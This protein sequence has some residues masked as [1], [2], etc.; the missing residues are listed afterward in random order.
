MLNSYASHD[1]I[2]LY[3]LSNGR[4][5]VLYAHHFADPSK[6]YTLKGRTYVHTG[7]GN[8]RIRCID[9]ADGKVVRA[10]RRGT[11]QQYLFFDLP[12]VAIDL[13]CRLDRED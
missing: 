2:N 10:D 1:E 9:P 3:A 11:T 8:F 4:T 6:P 12:P 7:A 13:A 5:A